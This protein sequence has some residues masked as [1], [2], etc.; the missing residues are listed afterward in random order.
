MILCKMHLSAES[1]RHVQL[2]RAKTI[3]RRV[4]WRPLHFV[5]SCVITTFLRFDIMAAIFHFLA[6]KNFGPWYSENHTKVGCTK[7]NSYCKWSGETILQII[8]RQYRGTTSRWFGEI[9]HS[10]N[11]V[12]VDLRIAA[13]HSMQPRYCKKVISS[14]QKLGLFGAINFNI[15]SRTHGRNFEK[16]SD[17]IPTFTKF[18]P[19]QLQCLLKFYTFLLYYAK[20]S[21]SFAY[22]HFS[23]PK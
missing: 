2:G 7:L 3:K 1:L 13:F 8:C 22:A 10:K 11:K 18:Q 9:F 23:T 14:G 15:T 16:S 5:W 20:I 21:K 17:I 4:N 12:L 19:M 6:K